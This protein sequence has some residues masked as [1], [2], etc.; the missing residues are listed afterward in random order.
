MGLGN[1]IFWSEIGSGF[2]ELGGTTPPRIPRSTPPPPATLGPSTEL[3]W[4]DARATYR[5]QQHP[6]FEW[7]GN[8]QDRY[9]LFCSPKLPCLNNFIPDCKPSFGLSLR[10]KL[11]NAQNTI[12]FQRTTANFILLI[13]LWL[14][15]TGFISLLVSCGLLCQLTIHIC[16]PVLYYFLAK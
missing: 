2:R 14:G 11:W 1:Y 15:S 3:C 16:I 5:K 13:S 12:F 8:G 9:I 4:A 6:N 7:R 10:M